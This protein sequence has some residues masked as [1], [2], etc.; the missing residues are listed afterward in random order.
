M[1]HK[2][3]NIREDFIMADLN[4]RIKHEMAILPATL[5]GYKRKTAKKWDD[6]KIRDTKRYEKKYFK[7][8]LERIHK[9]GFL[10]STIERYEIKDYTDT[11]Y[12]SDLDLLSITPFNNTF[13]KWIDDMLTLNYILNA[14]REVCRNIYFSIIQRDNKK[15]ILPYGTEIRNCGVEDIVELLKEK[16]RLELRPSYWQSKYSY[17]MLSLTDE[18]LFKIYKKG[19]S[20]VVTDDEE[21]YKRR[22][23]NYID[24]LLASYVVA[25]KLDR[26]KLDYKGFLAGEH[27]EVS[28][29]GSLKRTDEENEPE[30]YAG[31]FSGTEN[32]EAYLRMSQTNEDDEAENSEND[33]S[34]EEDGE[35]EEAAAAESAPPTNKNP[36]Y[37]YSVQLWVANDSEIGTKVLSAVVNIFKKG[38]ISSFFQKTVLADIDDGSFT[39]EAIR[40]RIN[41]WEKIISKVCEISECVK[42]INF[43]MISVIPDGE[44]FK[45]FSVNHEP[46]LP[47][48]PYNR[49]LGLYL[50]EKA[51]GPEKGSALDTYHDYKL[52][53]KNK[54][55]HERA[56]SESRK[57]MRDYMYRLWLDAWEDDKKHTKGATKEQKQWAWD[58]GFLS[59]R[60]WQY[61]LT[62]ENVDFILSDYDY[63]WLNRINNLYQKWV[64]DKTTYR[65]IMEPI[66]KYVPKYYY[67][68][69]K[70]GGKT[71]LAKMADLP[72]GFDNNTD[73][74]IRLLEE[75]SNLVFKPSAGTHGDG[76]YRFEYS[77]GEYILNGKPSSKEEIVN[78]INS[79]KSFYIIT[80]CLSMHDELRRFYPKSVNTIR[81]MVINSSGYEPKIMQTYMRIG[82]EKTGFTDNVGY[83][84]ICVSI[85]KETGELYNPQTLK[86][87]VY[88]ECP[89]HPD[90]NEPISGIVPCWQEMREAVLEIAGYLKEL[91]Y[92][93]FDVA[94]T[95]E[96]IKVLE[97]NIHQDLHKV[98][99]YTDEI[100]EFF[101]R[102]KKRK[103]KQYGLTLL[104]MIPSSDVIEMT[105]DSQSAVRTRANSNINVKFVS[106]RNRMSFY[107]LMNKSCEDISVP[108]TV[109]GK[110]VT[111][112]YSNAFNRCSVLK[113]V[114]LPDT[115][116]SIGDSAF[117]ICKKLKKLNMPKSLKTIENSAFNYCI[118]LTD[119]SLPE[120]LTSIGRRAF[121]DC[122]GLTHVLI[123]PTVTSIGEE[124]F[125]NC[126]KLT[127][128]VEEGS[129][130]EQYCKDNELRYI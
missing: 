8:D 13:T 28:D 105:L 6:L 3:I 85:D 126:P 70:R 51:A 88:Y 69:F 120:G 55:F 94:I 90:T 95:N 101:D 21:V 125:G 81:V 59:F 98:A 38:I 27:T 130:A 71:E 100:N 37:E 32:D 91:E 124:A 40:Y 107:K 73:D 42:Q 9:A 102:V 31:D 93:G 15:I 86:N 89:V 74:V 48:V 30:N 62:E 36:E 114:D 75:V 113:S 2:K 33:I 115:V 116:E 122:G 44:L 41:N 111:V 45:I 112:V 76:F 61:N 43:F 22:L 67:S 117:Y 35:G 77:G 63:F 110:K 58:H 72:A 82:S 10:C 108:E 17:Y 23:S 64:N 7:D 52:A 109:N 79:Q 5:S 65:L 25:D 39:Y 34:V 19:R 11:Y 106:Y 29:D 118:S 26:C 78:V 97:I 83:G 50:K 1:G 104:D 20:V 14:H 56:Q 84:G 60:L 87:H 92:L 4:K 49:E 80:E 18:G 24:A 103:M 99:E 57:G 121:Y 12:V 54:R 119:I 66:K 127:A 53:L 128:I 16:K 47:S 46:P 129:Y 123:P 96:G 68:V